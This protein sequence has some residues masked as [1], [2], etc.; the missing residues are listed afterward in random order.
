MAARSAQNGSSARI[1]IGEAVTERNAIVITT[2]QQPTASVK[3]LVDLRP[4]WRC[5]VIGDRKTPKGWHWP[6]VEYVPVEEQAGL[7][8]LATLLPFDHYARKNIGYLLAIRRH[9]TAIYETD[10][11]NMPYDQLLANCAREVK[12][13]RITSTGWENVYRHFSDLR[14]WPRGFPLECVNK[15]FLAP[16][17]SDVVVEKVCPI[18]QFLSDGDPDV[19][20][21]YR[22]INDGYVRFRENDI[23]L[24]QGSFCPFNSQNTLWWPEAYPLLY[25][26]SHVN[27][28]LTDIWRSFVALACMH[29]AGYDI[30]FRSATVNQNRNPHDLMRDFNDELPGYVT[31]RHIMEVLESLSLSP[32][33]GNMGANL[34]RCYVAL[35]QHKIVPTT[36]LELI[37]AWL[38]DIADA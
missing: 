9:A 32:S 11:D 10:D 24:G 33:T 21:I 26:P 30:A 7:G 25:L 35:I 34:R 8:R 13:R 15:S 17:P 22:L 19:D 1:E 23:L 20:A 3:R 4:E 31:N 38:A 16:A 29:S 6:R 18:Q 27:F 36:E 37:D 12:G 14:I 5:V 2:V 28:R